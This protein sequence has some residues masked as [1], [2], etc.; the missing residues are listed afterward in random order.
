MAFSCVLS[1]GHSEQLSTRTLRLNLHVKNL[2]LTQLRLSSYIHLFLHLLL[3]GG[4][5]SL[6]SLLRLHR[7]LLPVATLIS[8]LYITV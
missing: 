2:Q 4:L 7:N 1:S 3:Q 6:P 8:S 5:G